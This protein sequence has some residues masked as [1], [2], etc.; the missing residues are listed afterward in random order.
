MLV[1][2]WPPSW[3]VAVEDDAASDVE[4]NVEAGYSL[5]RHESTGRNT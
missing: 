1:V 4:S 5:Y 3:V 2:V